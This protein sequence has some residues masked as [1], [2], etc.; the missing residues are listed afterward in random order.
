MIF[1]LLHKGYTDM[2]YANMGYICMG[3]IGM[4]WGLVDGRW[5]GWVGVG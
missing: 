2:G 4:A 3:C 5:D 1:G